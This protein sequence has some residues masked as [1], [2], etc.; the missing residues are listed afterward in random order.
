MTYFDVPYFNI[1]IVINAHET[2]H[3]NFFYRRFQII[4]DFK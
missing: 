1:K 3:H 4:I 2:A